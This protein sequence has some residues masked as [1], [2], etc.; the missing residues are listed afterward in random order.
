LKNLR[1]SI[2][3]FISFL[4]FCQPRE[5]FQA[6]FHDLRLPIETPSELAT[7]RRRPSVHQRCS[8]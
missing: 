4:V 7:P 8:G 1:R 2:G 3:V 5:R 6:R